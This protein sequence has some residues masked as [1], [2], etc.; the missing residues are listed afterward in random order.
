VISQTKGTKQDFW[1]PVFQVLSV[2]FEPVRFHFENSYAFYNSNIASENIGRQV[3][4]EPT[5][6]W[7][8]PNV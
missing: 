4:C 5:V 2:S 8:E 7:K 3:I 6:P 1:G